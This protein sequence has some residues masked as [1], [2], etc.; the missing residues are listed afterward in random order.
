VVLVAQRFGRGRVAVLAT[1][2][3]WRWRLALPSESRD[4]EYFW[5]NLAGWLGD[6]GKITRGGWRLDSVLT[7]A[8]EKMRLRFVAPDLGADEAARLSFSAVDPEGRSH[9]LTLL[10]GEAGGWRGEFSPAAPGVWKL[11]AGSFPTQTVTVVPRG[12]EREL[13]QLAPDDNLFRAL[14]QADGT[15]VHRLSALA[16]D[17]QKLRAHASE[18]DA[19]GVV[20]LTKEYE[21]ALW[22]RWELF[23]AFLVLYLAE[24]LLRRFMA[25]LV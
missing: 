24:L 9:A 23:V 8:G 3:L 14:A 16:A 4:C 20:R 2:P 11:C 17:P 7:G 18:R 10:P 5:G 25:K 22:W 15:L 12:G 21:T 19:A 1:D 6:S 13:E